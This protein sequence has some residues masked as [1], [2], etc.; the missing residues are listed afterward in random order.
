MA[1]TDSSTLNALFTQPAAALTGTDLQIHL[2]L[3]RVLLNEILA[4]RPANTPIREL[5]IDPNDRNRF[6]VHLTAEAPIVGTVSR[7]IRLAPGMPVSFPDQPWLEFR[8]EEG[9]GFFDRSLISVL[10]GQI[11]KRLPRGIELT[12]KNLRIHVPALL[13]YLGYQQLAPLIES[14]EIK[15]E[16]SRLLVNLHLKAE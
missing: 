5:L 11:E 1:I 14:L 2:P 8:I 7:Q 15:S 13:A 16:A 10:Q 3:T 6:R 12:S 4:A 9:L